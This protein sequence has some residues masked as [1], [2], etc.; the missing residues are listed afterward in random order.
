MCEICIFWL[1][2]SQKYIIQPKWLGVRNSFFN[3]TGRSSGGET[4]GI[5][6]KNLE[7]GGSYTERHTILTHQGHMRQPRRTPRRYRPFQWTNN[8]LYKENDTLA[9]RWSIK[10]DITSSPTQRPNIRPVKFRPSLPENQNPT[11]SAQIRT[12]NIYDHVTTSTF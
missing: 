9:N 12:E 8:Q 11:I 7:V 5:H 2:L 1:L 10:S 3:V 4:Y 6:P